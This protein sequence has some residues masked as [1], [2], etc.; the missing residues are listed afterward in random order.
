[1]GNSDTPDL[2]RLGKSNVNKQ[3]IYQTKL[4]DLLDTVKL[5]HSE[6]K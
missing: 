4:T 6:I 3:I 1:M 2:R 5:K